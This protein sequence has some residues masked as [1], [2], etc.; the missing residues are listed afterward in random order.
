MANCV[1]G[2]LPPETRTVWCPN[3]KTL[4][5]LHW[6]ELCRTRP[7]YRAAWDNGTGPGQA[8]TS[9]PTEIPA[10]MTCQHRGRQAA[11]LPA[12]DYGCGCGFIQLHDC[13][14]FQELTVLKL[15]NEARHALA[16]AV[17]NYT[18]RTCA[19]CSLYAKKNSTP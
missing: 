1:C 6:S 19:S 18:G 15:R 17:E 12:R 4:K 14:H 5:T 8:K 13:Q 7:A 11:Q 3:H 9:T 10:W 16:A 2:Q